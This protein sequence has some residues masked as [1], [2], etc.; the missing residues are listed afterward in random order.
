MGKVKYQVIVKYNVYDFVEV[1]LDEDTNPNDAIE[2]AEQ[3]SYER[4]LEDMSVE[5]EYIEFQD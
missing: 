5:L 3:I 2:I 4:S 1:E